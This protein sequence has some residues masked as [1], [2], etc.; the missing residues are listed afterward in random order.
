MSVSFDWD[1]SALCGRARCICRKGFRCVVPCANVFHVSE[2]R[3]ERSVFLF[4]FLVFSV[5]SSLLLCF[6]ANVAVFQIRRNDDKRK[7]GERNY[8]D[9]RKTNA[10]EK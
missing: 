1:E 7:A 10:A 3:G 2:G 8:K 6:L 4:L 5:C 9:K